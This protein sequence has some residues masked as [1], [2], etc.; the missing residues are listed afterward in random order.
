MDRNR[1]ILF[2]ILWIISFPVFSQVKYGV[3]TG[4]IFNGFNTTN[5]EYKTKPSFQIGGFISYDTDVESRIYFSHR[6]I[7]LTGFIPK[8]ADKIEKVDFYGNYIELIPISVDFWTKNRKLIT[9]K[10]TLNINAGIY[11]SYCF[12]AKGSVVIDGEKV[13]LKNIYKNSELTINGLKYDF[14]A[15]R[16]FGFGTC[17]GFKF[18]FLDNYLFRAYFPISFINLTKYDKIIQYHAIGLS[19]GYVF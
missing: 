15:F 2:T 6:G 18:L 13:E 12:G 4:Y 5:V 1:I 11:T 3:E 14:K 16:P 17:I 7:S 9:D 10:L 8:Y 19:L